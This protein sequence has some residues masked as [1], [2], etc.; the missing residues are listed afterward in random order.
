MRLPF[1]K[2]VYQTTDNRQQT[3]DN[4][5]QTTD[6]P[7]LPRNPQPATRNPQPATRNP[8]PATPAEA[9]AKEGNPLK[10]N[11]QPKI[12]SNVLGS[13]VR[14]IFHLCKGPVII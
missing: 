11:T 6:N 3:T 7:V 9:L 12:R 8:Q 1:M 2:L 14:T 13:L 10:L 5:Q 4:R